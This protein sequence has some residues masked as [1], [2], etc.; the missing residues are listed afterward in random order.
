M[1]PISQQTPSCLWT[2]QQGSYT[3]KM[4]PSTGASGTTRPT[5]GQVQHFLNLPNRS[6]GAKPGLGTIGLQQLARPGGVDP[7]LS[8][9]GGG[10]YRRGPALVIIV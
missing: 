6:E 5:Q 7:R 4:H 9:G 1:T 2:V 3:A 10:P 8:G